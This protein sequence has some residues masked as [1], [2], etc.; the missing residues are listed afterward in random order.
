MRGAAL[1]GETAAE[2]VDLVERL[3]DPT[4]DL[5][6]RLLVALLTHGDRGRLLRELDDAL[7]G[8]R[9][10]PARVAELRAS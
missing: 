4:P 1:L 7:L 5:L 10:G 8:L 6:R 3:R 2:R 9:A